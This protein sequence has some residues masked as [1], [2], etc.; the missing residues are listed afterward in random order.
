MTLQTP[1]SLNLQL[2]D[3]LLTT[4][5]ALSAEEQQLLLDRLQEARDRH[6]IEQK[7]HL[8]EQQYTMKSS[9]FYAQFL[10]GSLGDS[11]D[12]IEWAGFYEML[13]SS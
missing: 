10:T 2:I 6:K 4:I 8:Y 3:G 12:Y 9:D 11:E 13:H 1:P 5:L 7:L